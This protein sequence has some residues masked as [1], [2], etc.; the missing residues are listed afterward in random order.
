[1][2]SRRVL[3]A[4]AAVAALAAPVLVGP[5]YEPSQLR[6]HSGAVWLTSGRAGEATLVDGTSAEVKTHVPVN[7]ASVALTVVQ[8]GGDAFVL[9]K[10]T[11]V[12]NRVDGATEHVSP[13]VSVLPAGDGLVVLSSSNVVRV[14]DV[15]SGTVASVDPATL[16][17]KGEPEHLAEAIKP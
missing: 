17:A 12:L 4:L 13:P 11:G 16:A 14:V 9:D 10:R 5:G 3:V 7:G 1:M 8:Q 2:K 6:M 15:R